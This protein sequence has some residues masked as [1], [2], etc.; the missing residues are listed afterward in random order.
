MTSEVRDTLQVK[1]KEMPLHLFR[2][3]GKEHVK[4]AGTDR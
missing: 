4:I 3:I 2:I 1:S